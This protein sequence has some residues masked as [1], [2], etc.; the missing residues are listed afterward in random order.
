MD[1]SEIRDLIGWGIG[2]FATSLIALIMGIIN[3]VK[4]GK[5]L[6]SE[7]KGADL[8]NKSKEV[9]L[10]DQ[11]DILATKAAEKV[12]KMQERLDK[13]DEDSS[14]MRGNFEAMQEDY[15][16][17]KDKVETQDCIIKKQELLIKEQGKRL[18]MQ[19][20]TIDGQKKEI[21]TLTNKL[22]EAEKRNS[23]LI[24]QLQTN[25][26][27]VI[28]TP[29]MEADKKEKPKTTKKKKAVDNGNQV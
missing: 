28:T 8:N 21:E 26:N 6:P 20:N 25:G 27:G 17:L 10:A 24:K 2:I 7:L 15:E 13:I 1:F 29:L 3:I 12:L 5:M 19:D 22:N 18:D 9:S 11:Y 14:I 4:S 16:K 23:E